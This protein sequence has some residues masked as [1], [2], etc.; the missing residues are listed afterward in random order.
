MNVINKYKVRIDNPVVA[1]N[2]AAVGTG[3]TSATWV[4]ANPAATGIL[5]NATAGNGF[6]KATTVLTLVYEDHFVD[7]VLSL[8]IPA[9]LTGG[10]DNY[11]CAP[12]TIVGIGGGQRV[13][14]VEILGIANTENVANTSDLLVNYTIYAALVIS[15]ETDRVLV[16][17]PQAQIPNIQN[18]TLNLRVT[19]RR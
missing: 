9:V 17:I 11:V 5:A 14:G 4:G 10:Q 13:E 19:Y 15:V 12:F 2:D 8:K 18:K 1:T 3:I 6:S 7:K 16:K